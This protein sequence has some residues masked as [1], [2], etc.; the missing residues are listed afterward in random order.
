[1]PPDVGSRNGENAAVHHHG[2]AVHGQSVVH[3]PGSEWTHIG[4]VQ[5]R[6]R[7]SRAV[8]VVAGPPDA[9]C[10]PLC[11][12]VIHPIPWD[13]LDGRQPGHASI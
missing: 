4:R 11:L 10:R 1:M 6:L 13:P 5:G 8:E 9:G 12:P 2:N 3:E 7:I